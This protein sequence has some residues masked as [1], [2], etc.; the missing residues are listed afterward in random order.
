MKICYCEK[1][2][3]SRQAMKNGAK[4]CNVRISRNYARKRLAFSRINRMNNNSFR[5]G[6]R[7]GN[8]GMHFEILRYSARILKY[9]IF[10]ETSSVFIR[11][12]LIFSFNP[13]KDS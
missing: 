7:F 5:F 8:L 2:L 10:A 11:I 6:D 3:F 4:A 9:P 12:N 13:K 1:F